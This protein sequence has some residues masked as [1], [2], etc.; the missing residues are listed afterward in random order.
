MKI[1]IPTFALMGAL[2]LVPGR[3]WAEASSDGLRP[4]LKK[5]L[6]EHGDLCLGKF[7]WPIGVS[8]FDRQTRTRDAVQM[9][10][11]E[12]MGLVVSSEGSEKRKE[13]DSE[14][15]VP[16]TFYE[17]TGKGKKF[18]LPKDTTYVSADGR[19]TVRHGDFCAGKLRLDAIAGWD[20]PKPVE[21]QLETTV[22][23]T[24]KFS[25]AAWTRDPEA[26]KVFPMVDRVIQ[27]EGT[28]QLQQLFRLTNGRWIAV[29]P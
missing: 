11:L 3:N 28:A 26:R 12:K 4:A 7:D 17:L 14:K 2:L 25:A 16:V 29:A 21:G 24:Y 19:K 15:T 23:Y 10:V 5:Y 8:E 13:G 1:R 9:P 20:A 22:S 18:Y 27:G 6:K